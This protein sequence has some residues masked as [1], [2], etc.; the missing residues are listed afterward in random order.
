M[1]KRPGGR[2]SG[3]RLLIGIGARGRGCT[4]T[5]DA[6]DVVPLLLGYAGGRPMIGSKYGRRAG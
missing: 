6:L 4:G 5:G 2:I 1:I 3:F